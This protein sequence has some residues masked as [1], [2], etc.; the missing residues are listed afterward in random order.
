MKIDKWV[1][2]ENGNRQVSGLINES[3]K[4]KQ[5]KIDKWMIRQIKRVKEEGSKSKI[6]KAMED[7]NGREV[8]I[9]KCDSGKWTGQIDKWR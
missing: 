5:V 3:E 4:Q 9:D 2:G 1:K 6:N 7:D 8:K